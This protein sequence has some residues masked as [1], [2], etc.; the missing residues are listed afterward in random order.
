MRLFRG[1]GAAF[2]VVM[3]TG[4]SGCG[5]KPPPATPSGP[6]AGGTTSQMP[7]VAPSRPSQGTT[8]PPAPAVSAAPTGSPPAP[9]AATGT[10][11][12]RD[13][14]TR[15]D[16]LKKQQVRTREQFATNCHSI[17]DL[18]SKLLASN[19][20]PAV[21]DQARRMW[22]EAVA[23][24]T[25]SEARSAANLLDSLDTMA[26]QII[27]ETPESELAAMAYYAKITSHLNVERDGSENDPSI[28]RRLFDWT[29]KFAERFPKEQRVSTVLF[30]IGQ[31]AEGDGQ[32]DTAKEIF[33]FLLDRRPEPKLAAQVQDSLRKL[34]ML[35]KPLAIAGPTLKGGKIN[36]EKL[37]GKVVLVDFWATWCGPCVAELP[38]VQK[39]YEK[40]HGRGF[41]IIA[42]SF[43][44]SRKPLEKFVADHKLR[45]AQIFFD[46]EGQQGWTNP[47]GRQ[48]G[49]D[50]IPATFLVNREGNLAKIGVRGPTLESAVAEL[51]KR[52]AAAQ[53]A[54]E[55][56]AELRAWTDSSGQFRI[57]AELVG[58]AD[59]KVMLKK[60]DG[61][62]VS[63]PV[64]RLSE[65]DQEWLRDHPAAR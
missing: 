40:Y 3:A 29:K 39:V 5:Y 65:Q 48:Y 64:E 41:E 63:V 35:G 6:G 22:M 7:P 25:M 59:A 62:V 37:K 4:L 15:I 21:R 11:V 18:S 54:N 42:V 38:N 8:P 45:W 13:L 52:P 51:L 26:D 56:A 61:K 24:V 33:K 36:I 14:L 30:Q 10:A 16:D 44:N 49:I 9:A 27:T 31:N 50:A 1:V 34:E 43:D 19:P 12:S 57:E 58:L 20:E 55:T 32:A 28:N 2:A 47:L 17:M 60:A 53:K 46:K 23:G